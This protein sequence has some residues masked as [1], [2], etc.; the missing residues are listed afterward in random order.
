VITV[1]QPPPAS[2]E[3]AADP[4]RRYQSSGPK[5]LVGLTLALWFMM[6][7]VGIF[8]SSR[9]HLFSLKFHPLKKYSVWFTAN[10]VTLCLRLVVRIKK[11]TLDRKVK[12]SVA[13]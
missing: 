6:L 2:C 12:K 10:C 8:H 1:T 13:S 9:F 3:P 4:C 11:L 5:D 7:P